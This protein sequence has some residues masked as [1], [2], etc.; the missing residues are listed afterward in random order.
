[1]LANELSALLAQRCEEIV[2]DLLP[3][4][5]KKGGEWCAG[6]V[7][8]EKGESLKVRLKGAKAGVWSDFQSGES[9]D[10]L[11]LW[12]IT[13]SLSISQTMKEVS[14]QFNVLSKNYS[15]HDSYKKTFTRPA[16]KD[17]ESLKEESPVHKY[18]SEV[19]GLNSKTIFLYA[20][21]HSKDEIIFNYYREQEIIFEKTLKLQRKDGKKQVFVSANAEPCLFGWQMIPPNDRK[22]IICEGE[23]DAMSFFQYGYP[24][25]SVPFGG[26]RGDKQRWLDYEI[27]R[28]NRFDEIFICM[29]N[30]DAGL[31]GAREIIGRLGAHRC[32]VIQLPMKDANECL[33]NGMS[34][35]DIKYYIDNAI[36]FDPQELKLHGD[37]LHSTHEFMNPTSGTFMGYTLGWDNC[38]QSILF[39]PSGLTMWTGYNGHGKTMF[40]GHVMLNML[41]Q[42]A[43]ICVASM[44][45]YPEELMARTYMQA[46]AMERPSLDYMK[47]I[48]DWID[49]KL[50][51]FNLIG[52]AKID[53]MLE[54]FLYARRR[55]G[56]DVFI[57]DSLTTLSIAEDDYNAQ[58]ELTEKLR[59]FKLQ[60]NCHIH[61]VAHPR[62]PRDEG[63]IPGKYD[64]RGGGAISDLAD[65]CFAVWRNKKKESIAREQAR[66]NYLEPEEIEILNQPDAYLRCDKNR[67][68]RGKYKEGLFAFWFHEP[69]NQYLDKSYAKAKPYIEYSCVNKE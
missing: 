29:D 9:G 21:P 27:E 57:I 38:E 33:V 41:N 65:N 22:V 42:G 26:G 52:T 63:E 16:K 55:Y 46:T 1:M 39:K 48:D 3:N 64:I 31:E 28:L 30:D 37:F 4:G 66:G 36:T 51:I 2:R 10:L 68:G 35:Q 18:L 15:P 12:A 60:Y 20:I 56:L 69:S 47:A 11:D 45:L 8:G 14:E 40:L 67:H 43:R 58:K 59:D 34:F 62:K 25:L 13:K 5:E 50:M 24:A 32:R 49:G 53:R 54:V 19:R 44:E 7:R 23:I 61:L 17:R 6:S